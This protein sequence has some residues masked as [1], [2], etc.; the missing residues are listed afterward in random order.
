MVTQD[1]TVAKLAILAWRYLHLLKV[2]KLKPLLIC[3]PAFK[4]PMFKWPFSFRFG[5]GYAGKKKSKSALV[6]LS[7]LVH[8]WPSPEKTSSQNCTIYIC[9][10]SVSSKGTAE[11]AR[12][13]EAKV[14]S[15]LAIVE[16]KGALIWDTFW[17]FAYQ[18]TVH[19]Q[20]SSTTN[21]YMYLRHC[22]FC[23]LSLKFQVCR[24]PKN[25][26]TCSR[27]SHSEISGVVP[28]L[29]DF[30]NLNDSTHQKL[31]QKLP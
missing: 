30:H 10:I 27:G 21:L 24:I 13:S 4:S 5:C 7:A 9:F 29:G 20:V 6:I 31:T 8:I 22:T 19:H 18:L 15:Q 11:R 28:N 1:F 3:P 2:R 23:I 16:G 17:A 12:K 14:H 26:A 25:G